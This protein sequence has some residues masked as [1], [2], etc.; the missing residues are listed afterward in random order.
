[1]TDRERVTGADYRYIADRNGEP[2]HRCAGGQVGHTTVI[3]G[4]QIRTGVTAILPHAGNLFC[5]KVPGAVFI[6]N[7][8]G[9]LAGSTQVKQRYSMNFIM[10]FTTVGLSVNRAFIGKRDFD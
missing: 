10:Q 2:H 8:Y 5:E 6:G 4:D 7:A 3:R 9:K 1:M